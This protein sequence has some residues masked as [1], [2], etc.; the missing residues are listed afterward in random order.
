MRETEFRNWLI[1]QGYDAGTVSSRV[2]NCLRIDRYEEDL[3]SAYQRDNCQDLLRRLT[4]STADLKQKIA[5]LHRIP[6][7]GNIRNG[8]ATLKQALRLYIRFIEDDGT[9][10][11]SE[12]PIIELERPQDDSA[13]TPQDSYAQFLDYF[14][15]EPRD[16]YS[17]GIDHTIFADVDDASRQWDELKGALLNDCPITIRGYGRNGKNTGI[18]FDFYKYLFNNRHI[19]K[20]A[21]NNSTPRQNIQKYTGYKINAI[22]FNYQC[23]HVFGHT[24]NPLL[25]EAVWNICFTPKM[26]DPLTGH[27]ATG[28]WPHEYQKLFQ[29]IAYKR[30]LPLIKDYNA[31]VIEMQIQDK[32]SEFIAGITDQ[33]DKAF[34]SR[35]EEDVRKEWSP[36]YIEEPDDF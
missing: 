23:S 27:E 19:K 18:F 17:F 1:I 28:R 24:K 22:L 4:Y 2:S 11:D 34:L 15:L 7:T 29:S 32:I 25:F 3:D 26:F 14:G 30:F 13:I 21:T 10:F 33:Y 8:T 20:D 31:F 16:F 5:P 35:F 36:I 9:S 12:P 6:M